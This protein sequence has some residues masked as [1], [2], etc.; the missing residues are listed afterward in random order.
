[1]RFAREVQA[2]NSEDLNILSHTNVNMKSNI[3]QFM[4]KYDEIRTL[5]N[6]YNCGDASNSKA[7]LL[8][9]DL[10]SK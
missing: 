5:D 1:M 2:F 8:N 3:T 4:Q 9:C 6:L 7:G 10:R